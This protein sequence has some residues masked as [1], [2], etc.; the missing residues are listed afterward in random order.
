LAHALS[1]EGLPNLLK[2][3]LNVQLGFVAL[4]L[5]IV[6]A[7]VGWKWENLAA[8]MILL[9][10]VI[11]TIMERQLPWPPGLMPVVGFLYA[12]AWWGSKRATCCDEHL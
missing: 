9:G 6:G 12:V 5:M 3:S 1:A 8:V 4:L 11:W 2:A 7:V 10:C